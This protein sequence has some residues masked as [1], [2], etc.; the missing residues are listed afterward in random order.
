MRS[1]STGVTTVLRRLALALSAACAIGLALAATGAQAMPGEFDPGFGAGGISSNQFSSAP[2]PTSIGADVVS[3]PEGKVVVAGQIN[4]ALGHPAVGVARYLSN[5]Q[6]DP[7]FGGGSGAVEIQAGKGVAPESFAYYSALAVLADGRILLAGLATDVSGHRA[8]LVMRLKSSGETDPTFS[9]GTVILQLGEGATPSSEFFGLAL[10]PEGKIVLAGGA[11]EAA[12]HTQFV[13]ERLNSEGLPDPSFGKG[14]GT[15]KQQFGSGTEP[16]SLGSDVIAVPSGY[17]FSGAAGD[18]KHNM[19]F[20]LLKLTTSGE[21]FLSFGTA[22]GSTVQ[23]NA[24]PGF[25]SA[26]LR[27]V[28]QSS[29][30]LVE[31]GAAP[32]DEENH[33]AGA[34][35]RFTE[36]G[37]LDTSFGTGGITLTPLSPGTPPL[38]EGVGLVVQSNDR[39]VV[40]SLVTGNSSGGYVF[41]VARYTANGALD[42][43]F[44]SSGVLQRQLGSGA[45][46]TSAGLGAAIDPAGR[47]LVAGELGPANTAFNWLVARITLEDASAAPPG[48]P[49]A[50]GPPAPQP[51]APLHFAGVALAGSTL[52]MDRHGNV[53]VKLSSSL[54]AS[55]SVTL[56]SVSAFAAGRRHRKARLALGRASFQLVGGVARL[57]RI[58]LSARAQGLV[59]SLRRLRATELAVATAAGQ[60]RQ[61]RAG[62]TITPA[63]LRRRH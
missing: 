23:A 29:G 11:T 41:T 34:L 17:V 40:P 25:N 48:G 9:G 1:T 39:L 37:Q 27:V 57:V 52:V 62:V 2:S 28:Q 15:F 60:T 20:L 49:P 14:T 8:A 51:A 58:H 35:E 53:T 63:R 10:L 42:P 54:A 31:A 30:K 59:R 43:S 5:G 33:A 18:E 3:G 36:G 50:M 4:D 12:G 16:R 46:A 7:S 24:H 45:T 56:T 13:A 44:G 22:G 21:P 6:L 61:T 55:G 38:T 26:A 19:S 47:L 32:Y